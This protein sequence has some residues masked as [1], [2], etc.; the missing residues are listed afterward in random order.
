MD[1]PFSIFERTVNEPSVGLFADQVM[2]FPGS[3]VYHKVDAT[4][5]IFHG[6]KGDAFGGT[7]SLT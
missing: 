7:W 4:G 5:F 2:G 3:R 1:D 6:D